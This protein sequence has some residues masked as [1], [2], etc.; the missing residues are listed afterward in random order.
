MNTTPDHAS[1]GRAL[2]VEPCAG[3]TP[4]PGAALVSVIVRSMDRPSLGAALD[5]VVA[6][7]HRPIELVIVNALGQRHRPLPARCGGLPVVGVAAGDGQPL[8]RARAANHGLDAASGRFV[9][10]LDDDDLLLPDHLSRLV[11]AL[12]AAPEAPAAHADVAQG[13]LVA[14]V[15]QPLHCFDAGFDPVRLLFENYLPIHGVLFRRPPPGTTPRFDES[16]DLF[17]DWDFWLQ[18]AAQGDFVHV[19]GVSAW[20][21]VSGGDQSDVFSQSA[22]ARAARARLLEKWRH[23]AKPGQYAAALE[24][25]QSLYRDAPQLQAEARM[26]RA[27]EAESRRIIEARERELAATAAHATR[28][29]HVVGER[30]REIAATAAHAAGLQHVVDER[31]REIAATAAHAAGLQHRIDEGE[32]SLASAA[33]HAAGLRDLIAEREK[34]ISNAL[35]H[36]D[37][38]GRLVAARQDEVEHALTEIGAL[39]D[40][41]AAREREVADLTRA[42]DD[43]ARAAAEKDTQIAALQDELS[44]RHAELTRLHAELIALQ[45]EGP[46]QALRRTLRGKPHGTP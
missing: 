26:L 36:A 3:E 4:A 39:R 17:E 28:L 19:P 8:R 32:R 21:L 37:A 1:H 44:S 2:V 18:V 42:L 38:L 23:Q 45:A 27:G 13:R 24:R 29:Q 35:A 12:Q 7:T 33:A 41:L 14:G 46:L 25:L 40:V 5:S 22:A 6:Q 9:L 10:F 20:Y 34:E 31:E 15:W 43:Q 30:E 11:Q 16:F